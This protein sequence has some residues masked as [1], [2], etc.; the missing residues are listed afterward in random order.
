MKKTVYNFSK[1]IDYPYN[2]KTLFAEWIEDNISYFNE[3]G[4]NIHYE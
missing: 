2:G 4:K 3:N 1:I